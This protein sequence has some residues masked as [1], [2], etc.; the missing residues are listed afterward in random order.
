[1]RSRIDQ[2]L[3][4]IV[5]SITKRMMNYASRKTLLKG[6]YPDFPL[7]EVSSLSNFHTQNLDQLI[8]GRPPQD[9]L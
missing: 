8:E 1:M 9:V 5:L 2:L 4:I 7:K 3:S 6:E